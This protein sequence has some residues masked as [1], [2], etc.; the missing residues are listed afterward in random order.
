MLMPEMRV[1]MR[2]VK[3]IAPSD[4]EETERRKI[5]VEPEALHGLGPVTT[6]TAVA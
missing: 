6:E 4:K 5:L 3:A 2:A 1:A